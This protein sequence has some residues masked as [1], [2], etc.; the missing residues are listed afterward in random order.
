MPLYIT[1]GGIFLA[2]FLLALLLLRRLRSRLDPTHRRVR[3]LMSPSAPAADNIAI[4][5]ALR[6]SDLPAGLEKLLL[7]LGRIG[8]SNEK[9]HS[10]SR[11]L[12]LEAGIQH[13]MAPVMLM[14]MRTA[15]LLLFLL[16]Y[17]L[18][19]HRLI[20]QPMLML[21]APLAIALFSFRLPDLVLR[22]RITQRRQE[23]GESLADALDLLVICM[24][25][26]LG[27]NAAL[28][29]VAQELGMR[30]PVLSQELL[31]VTQ[32]MRTGLAREKALRNLCER[33]KVENLRILVGALILAD[34]LGTSVGDTLRAQAD[35]LRTRLRQSAEE[36][37][38]KA[39]IKMLFPLVLFI[40]PALFIVL[41]GP[42]FMSIMKTF[43][44]FAGN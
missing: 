22:Y 23:I 41:L 24:E 2:F 25:A 14:G 10:R 29:R 43:S 5:D 18:F 11:Q 9:E 33:N 44:T 36:Q 6:Q 42:G 15:S 34:K 35:S 28:L 27:L 16:G 4:H 3:Q 39:G 38:A 32:E 26:G 12:L 30:T 8:R 7:S 37:A 19:I 13:E 21:A 20:A 1:L 17:F 31:Q 40:F